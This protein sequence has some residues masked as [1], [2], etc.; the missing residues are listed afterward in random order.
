MTEVHKTGD[1]KKH[2]VRKRRI[3]VKAFLVMVVVIVSISG[4]TIAY[5]NVCITGDKAFSKQVDEAIVRSENWVKEHRSDILKRRNAALLTMLRECND[6][7]A[8]PVFADI[9]KTFLEA[10]QWH[11]TRCWNREVDPNWPVNVYEL[12]MTF[13]KETIDNKWI[14][15]AIAPEQ[16]KT[17]PEDMDMFAPE[18]WQRRQLTHQL[19]ALTILRNNKGTN[20]E[21]DKLI[22]HLCSRLSRELVFDAAVVDIYIQ[23]VAFILRAGFPEKIRRRWVERIIANQLSDGG[24]N[25]RW[26]CLGSGRRP[27]FSLKQP[28]SNQH[29]TV[30]AI[31][32]LYLV[33]YQYPGH[34]GLE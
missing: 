19:Y 5:N 21:L 32:A 34:F 3:P 2:A 26:F 8:T 18:K 17:T 6:V 27:A 13:E 1:N 16:I 33:R 7:K 10:P 25:D 31:L 4:G 9:V 24:W 28:A 23:K 12:R 30:Q 11:A 22:K 29:A 14:L 20:E 15:Y